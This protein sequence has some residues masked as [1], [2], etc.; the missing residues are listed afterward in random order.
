MLKTKSKT[1]VLTFF[2]LMA[3]I[4]MP[5]TFLSQSLSED[6]YLTKAFADLQKNPPPAPT[7]QQRNLIIQIKN[8]IEESAKKKRFYQI[9]KKLA[10]EIG[11][12]GFPVIAELL[13]SPNAWTRALSARTLY[14][15]DREKSLYFL[16]GQLTDEGLFD[17]MDDVPGYTVSTQAYGLLGQAKHGTNYF[18]IPVRENNSLN[19][20]A[21]VI[22]NY[23]SYHLPFCKWT[24]KICFIDTTRMFTEL[25]AKRFGETKKPDGY[26][27]INYVYADGNYSKNNR[28]QRNDVVNLSLGFLHYGNRTLKIRWDLSDTNI[29]R[30]KLI[31]PDGKELKL[32]TDGLPVLAENTSVL[33]YQWKQSALGTTLNLSAMYNLNQLGIYRFFYEY[34]PP[35]N[36]EKDEQSNPIHLWHWNGQDYGNYYEFIVN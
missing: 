8:D 24:N 7:E 16:I 22:Q 1:A 23:Y 5:S 19:I 12:T 20:K 36:Q 6:E 9:D 14:I 15:L 13:K 34:I 26:E 30:Y 21:K 2:T 3:T 32:K 10:E 17:Y 25:E 35:K 31:A 33:Q 28:F 18:S 11:W 29:H 27:G 4:L